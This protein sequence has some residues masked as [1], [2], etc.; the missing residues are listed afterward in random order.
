MASREGKI[1]GT[2]LEIAQ[3]VNDW[4]SRVIGGMETA[5][6]LWEACCIPS[7]LSGAGTWTEITATTEKKLNIL[8][9][10]YLKLVF[11]VSQGAPSAS[12]LWD[13]ATLDMSLRVWKEKVLLILHIRKLEH[14]TL[15]WQVYNEQKRNDW[16]G[17]AEDT[18]GIC[19]KLSIEDCNITQISKENYVRILHQALH[20]KNEQ[21]L[22]TLAKGKCERI[23]YEEYGRKEYVSKK[24]IF[25]V[26]NQYRTRYGL[27]AFAGNYQHDRRFAKSNWLCRC[28]KSREDEVHLRSGQCNVYSDIVERF[29]DLTDDESLVQFFAAVLERRDQLDK[30][31]QTPDGGN[32]TIVGANCV[33]SK[34]MISQSEDITF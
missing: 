19:E 9:C 8:Q 30:C 28:E 25:E 12:L 16:P 32:K 15:A 23:S 7:L 27:L 11:Q 20:Q 26:R 17:L 22:R 6:L 24:N 5:L 18:K 1:R 13:L 33:L 14:N 2:C 34:D 29:S 10:W 31:L 4:R 21:N 3:I